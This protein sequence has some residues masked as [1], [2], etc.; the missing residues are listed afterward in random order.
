L[1]E[2]IRTASLLNVDVAP[3]AAGVLEPADLTLVVLPADADLQ[4]APALRTATDRSQGIAAEVRV[5]GA[6]LVLLA[7]AGGGITALTRRE[8]DQNRLHRLLQ[9]CGP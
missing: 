7:V 8:L 3:V 1:A 2:L 4:H 9:S 6:Q 5:D